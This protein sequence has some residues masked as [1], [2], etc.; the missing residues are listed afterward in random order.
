MLHNAGTLV[1]DDE[2]T[3]NGYALCPDHS[4]RVAVHTPMPEVTPAMWDWWFGWHGC[5]SRR[6][7][8]WHPRAHLYAEWADGADGERRGRARYVGRTSYVDEYL[9]STLARASIR[10]VAPGELGF[11]ESKLAPDEQTVICA[12]VGSSQHP[13]DIG[14]LVH[15]VRAT[16]IGA[17]MRSR[18]WIG[19][20]H[21][22]SRAHN[23]AVR[24]AVAQ[25]GRRLFTPNDAS[26]RDLLVHCA[27]EMAHL[28]TRLPALHE[29]F[30]DT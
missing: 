2:P 7:K 23:P 4:I 25:V 1:D 6:Y 3:E 8:L 11:D 18:F 15:H 26:A 9:G 30:G 16:P 24:R 5:D 29:E 10:F 20:S 22:E 19:G 17:E 14:Y 12:R 13:V 28:A 21:I 27:Q